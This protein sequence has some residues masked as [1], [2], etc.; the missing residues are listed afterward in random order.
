MAKKLHK[1]PIQLRFT[2]LRIMPNYI[3]IDVGF[4]K[5]FTLVYVPGIGSQPD[6]AERLKSVWNKWLLSSTAPSSS[7]SMTDEE[8][9]KRSRTN[10]GDNVNE[11]KVMA[12]N[13]IDMTCKICMDK[14]VDCLT[15]CPH[16]AMCFDCAQQISACPISREPITVR[17]QKRII[18][19]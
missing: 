16:L 10:D 1:M 5:H 4:R 15:D 9:T 2:H 17:I 8:R 3:D 6:I 14:T 7:E 11:S 18:I 12:E 19:S 13:N